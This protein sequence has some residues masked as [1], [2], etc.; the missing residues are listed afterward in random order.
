MFQVDVLL[1]KPVEGR[2]FIEFSIPIEW[3]NLTD[4]GVGHANL[5]GQL[6]DFIGGIT[7]LMLATDD[8]KTSS[9]CF[10]YCC[11]RRSFMITDFTEAAAGVILNGSDTSALADGFIGVGIVHRKNFN[12]NGAP[13]L[14][15]MAM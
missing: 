7:I 12:T 15:G 10:T 8:V 3:G 6:G 11:I 13:P 9:C 14:I 2:I 4:V 1:V 5:F